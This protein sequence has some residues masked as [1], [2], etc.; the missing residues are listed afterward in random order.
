L[1]STPQFPQNIPVSRETVEFILKCL[2]VDE[3]KR[4]SCSDLEHHPIFYRRHTLTA[5]RPILDRNASVNRNNQSPSR[6]T[7]Y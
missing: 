1:R 6:N 4:F 5:P 2:S 3:A 7:E